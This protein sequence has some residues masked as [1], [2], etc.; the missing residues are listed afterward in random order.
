MGAVVLAAGAAPGLAQTIQFNY[1]ATPNTTSV[2]LD[3]I[4]PSDPTGDINNGSFTYNGSGF[5]S[6]PLPPPAFSGISGV[7][8]VG[9]PSFDFSKFLNPNTTDAFITNFSPFYFLGSCAICK[10]S[11]QAGEQIIVQ[12]S[13]GNV[14]FTDAGGTGTVIQA[15]A[16]SIPIRYGSNG[17][18]GSI[19]FSASAFVATNQKVGNGSGFISFNYTPDLSGVPG[20]LPVLGAS[21]AFAFSRKIRKRIS[22]AQSVPCN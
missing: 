16:G 9:S 14:S 4:S 21:I 10:N 22:M 20:P 3:P 1:Q 19:S 13:P 11:T 15:F 8:F 17:S 12:D 2:V 7:E 6:P 5:L 18:P